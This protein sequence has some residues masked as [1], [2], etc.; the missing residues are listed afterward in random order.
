VLFFAFDLLALD[1]EDFRPKPL[2]DR[3][4][5]LAKLL[6]KA[7]IRYV[8]HLEGDGP[9]IFEHACKPGLEG[10]VSKRVDL[11]YES[12][13]SKDWQKVKNKTHPRCSGSGKR[14]SVNA[15]CEP[16]FDKPCLE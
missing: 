1:D 6:T 2:L 4:Q 3:K 8:E 9:T 12:G 14:L 10:I 11:P 7:G 13:P 5:R 15:R 16:A